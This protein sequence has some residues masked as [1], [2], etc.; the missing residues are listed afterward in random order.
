MCVRFDCDSCYESFNVTFE[1]T[2]T[3][4]LKFNEEI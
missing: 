4:L 1:P 2:K 3:E